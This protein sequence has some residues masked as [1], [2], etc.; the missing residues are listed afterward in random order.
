[1]TTVMT[2]AVLRSASFL[3]VAAS[4]AC[5]ATADLGDEVDGTDGGSSSADS[6][7]TLSPTTSPPSE[8]STGPGASSETAAATGSTEAEPTGSTTE[9]EDPP[10]PTGGL[11]PWGFGYVEVLEVR[12]QSLAF[13]DFDGDGILDL[14][15]QR[16]QGNAWVLETF[17]GLGDG[18][19]MSVGDRTVTGWYSELLA[20]DFDG[21]GATDLAA[22]HG[23][24]D[25]SFAIARGDGAG[26]F[27]DPQSIP[28]DGFFGFGATAMRYDA[29]DAADLFVPLGHSQGSKV[30]RATAGGGFES[31]APV[32]P[33]SCYVSATA[34]A[35]LDGDGLDEV[36]ATGSCNAIPG[37]LPLAIYRHGSDGF[38]L[39]Q[40]MIGEQGPVFEGADLAVVDADGDGDLDAVT[41]TTLGLY[42]IEGDGDGGLQ[43]PPQLWPHA[44]EPFV[45]RLVPLTRATDGAA[46]FVLADGGG[47][48]AAGLVEPDPSPSLTTTEIDL[49]GRVVGAADFDGD[50]RPDVVVLHGQENDGELVGH[51]GIWLSDG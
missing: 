27:A 47:D 50:D 37:G 45:R 10:P 35:D 16:R 24:A 51:V 39:D 30:A 28:I 15:A 18:T 1:M 32:A 49:R 34:A 38:V 19:F 26:G 21:D 31:L 14:L 13:E 46:M 2:S 5:L 3:L 20:A 40:T 42:V 48:G 8:G 11:G 25:N 44:Y 22:V 6:S 7:A 43:A 23:Y 41:P 12:A 4:S 29:D 33:V 9:S 17:A 36:V